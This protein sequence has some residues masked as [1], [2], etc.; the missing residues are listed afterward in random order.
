MQFARDGN[1]QERVED[2][3]V[4]VENPGG[5]RQRDD[6]A[7]NRAGLAFVHQRFAGRV[8]DGG[9]GRRYFG[10]WLHAI[11]Y[12]W[13]FIPVAGVKETRP[14]RAFRVPED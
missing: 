12:G 9:L 7:M 5:E 10:D 11:G 1:Q 2:E 4:E 6:S 3:I 8:R 14:Q 13:L